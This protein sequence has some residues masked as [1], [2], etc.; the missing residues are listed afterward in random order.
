MA[1]VPK[2]VI[3]EAQVRANDTVQWY[4]TPHKVWAIAM[5]ELR[6]TYNRAKAGAREYGFHS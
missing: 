2:R 3:R 5:A 6:L 4:G 1:K